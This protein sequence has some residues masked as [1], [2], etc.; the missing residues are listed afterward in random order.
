MWPPRLRADGAPFA[1]AST[2]DVPAGDPGRVSD[3]QP[4]TRSELSGFAGDVVQSG[5]IQGGVH[6]HQPGSAGNRPPRQ[7]PNDVRGF[8]NR[9]AELD[10]LSEFLSDGQ[11]EFRAPAVVVVTGTAGVGK[12]SLAVHWAHRVRDRFADGQLYINLRGYDPGPPVAAEAA[13]DVFLQALGARV[14]EIPTDVQAKAALYRSLVADRRILVVLDNAATVGQVRPLLPGTASCLV[15]VTSRSRLPGLVVRDG[16]IR[17]KVDVLT[18]DE[19]VALVRAVIAEYRRDDTLEDLNELARLCARLPLALRIAA[20]RAAARPWMALAELIQDLRDESMLWDALSSDDDDEADA[21]RTVLAWSYRA[22]PQE[23]ARLFRRLGL[24]P[25]GEFGVGAA[26]ALAG[27]TYSHTRHLLDGLLATHL[28]EQIGPDRYQLH[29]LLRAYAIELV[30]N[31]EPADARMAS[32]H[33]VLSWYLSTADAAR[34]SIVRGSR[35]MPITLDSPPPGLELIHFADQAQAMAW[36]ETERENLMGATRAAA[37]AGLDRIA[38]QLPAVL[39]GIYDNRDPADTWLA[40]EQ[41]ALDAARRV[42]D[43]YGQGVILERM[44]IKFRKLQRVDEALVCFTEAMAIFRR[45]GNNF[46]QARVTNGL[47]LTYLRAHRLEEARATFERQIANIPVGDSMMSMHAVVTLNL[48]E[49]YLEL[50]RPSDVV[51]H[52]SEAIPVFRRFGDLA[53][54]SLALRLQGAAQCISGMLVEA[55]ASLERALEAIRRTGNLI[56]ECEIFLEFARLE[57]AE[58]S[59]AEALVSAQRAA[60]IAHQFGV[61]VVEAWAL[62]LTGMAYQELGRPGEAAPFHRQSIELHQAAGEHNGMTAAIGHLT[63]ALES[64][65]E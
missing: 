31:D 65:K 18:R 16:A 29:D 39:D 6:F 20:E 13:L 1:S 34:R 36:Y 4:T 56:S 41:V 38:W 58:G 26:S 55:R 33:R 8:V 10:R 37:S 50:G 44:G 59:P 3:P 52:I 11:Q 15:L 24:H 54:E 46:G 5:T 43:S 25:G 53:M 30:Q 51:A 23:T 60:L 22:L 45:E 62:D 35:Q 57:I 9:V 47:G 48:G 7:L 64:V 61:A 27:L 40:T 32:M 21:V 17:L 28:V 14:S 2:R 42:N 49:T 12:T 63:A 19:A